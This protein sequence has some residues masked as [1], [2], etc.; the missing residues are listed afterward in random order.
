VD[1]F[2]SIPQKADGAYGATWPPVEMPPKR[3]DTG[4]KLKA[5]AVS[6]GEHKGDSE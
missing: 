6:W 1:G 5:V 3:S 4:R 2:L